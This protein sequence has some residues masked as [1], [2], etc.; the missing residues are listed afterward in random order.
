MVG[1]S[2]NVRLHKTL[3]L[4]IS[5]DSD[6]LMNVSVGRTKH[7]H[8]NCSNQKKSKEIRVVGLEYYY[9]SMEMPSG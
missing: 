2:K 5:E 6:I 1:L 4:L 9:F 7:E 3:F 8:F